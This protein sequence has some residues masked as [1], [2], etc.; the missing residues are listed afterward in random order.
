MNK[1]EHSVAL[2]AFAMMLGV[3]GCGR[4]TP[5]QTQTDI[6]RAESASAK[7]VQEARTDAAEK[8]A[9][10][11]K[12]VTRT[13]VEIAH[14]SAATT[15]DLAFAESEAA[16]RV[17]LERCEAQEGDARNICRTRADAELAAAKAR[18]EVVKAATDPKA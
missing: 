11:R 13:Q 4:G 15:R 3:S 5:E 2:A 1:I 16:H 18:A 12:D 10:A 14:D 7:S 17:S 9:G 6:S 8:M